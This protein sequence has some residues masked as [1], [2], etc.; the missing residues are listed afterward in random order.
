M[1]HG[2]G[3]KMSSTGTPQR[4]RQRSINASIGG[5]PAVQASQRSTAGRMSEPLVKSDP[6]TILSN[7]QR[8]HIETLN[9]HQGSALSTD[10]AIGIVGGGLGGLACKNAKMTLHEQCQKKGIALPEYTEIWRSDPRIIPTEFVYAVQ[11][12]GRTAT[13][14]AHP[15]KKL[16]Q[17][18]A[19]T[20]LL[21]QL[22]P[23]MQP[24]SI[25]STLTTQP[26]PPVYRGKMV[27]IIDVENRSDVA[28]FLSVARSKVQSVDCIVVCAEKNAHKVANLDQNA[29]RRIIVTSS[30]KDA[31]DLACTELLTQALLVGEA[32]LVVVVTGDGF[33]STACSVAMDIFIESPT[34]C[35]S[36]SCVESLSRKMDD[37]FLH[38]NQVQAGQPGMIHDDTGV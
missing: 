4:R 15:T 9:K 7:M 32:K 13:G 6:D 20:V 23:A 18:A 38:M 2:A 29:A 28:S 27:L 17:Q 34:T 33:G 35:C 25:L 31:A 37:V 14:T 11:A 22:S 3:C 26:P 30:A 16:A 21:E 8:R 10:L 1:S 24:I 12:M 19:A 5:G 36:V